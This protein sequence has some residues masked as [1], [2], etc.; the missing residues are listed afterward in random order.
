MGSLDENSIIRRILEGT[1]TETGDRFFDALVI[2]LA[3]A[4]NTYGAWVTEY[5][6]QTHQLRAIALFM[7]G[8]LTH[9]FTYDVADTA[10][11]TVIKSRGLV[12]LPDNVVDLY[13][14]DDHARDLQ[15]VSYLGIPLMDD[16]ATV[17]GHL[18]VLD[19]A[20]MPE[21]SR[22]QAI[23]KIF[24]ARAAAELQRLKAEQNV[25]ASEDKYRRI[26]ETAG[27]G[28]ILMDDSHRIVDVNASFCRL[29]GFKRSEIIGRRPWPVQRSRPPAGRR[30]LQARYPR[31]SP[32]RFPEH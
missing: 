30:Q 27:E 32:R 10:C 20:P 4:L 2:N 16:E 25:Q 28:F 6:P 12:H 9:G 26:V 29:I 21:Q 18:S 19:R 13:P 7:G 23:F 8:E 31:L 3:A 15:A 5:L 22:Q 24:A 11:E 14:E 1:A 17:L